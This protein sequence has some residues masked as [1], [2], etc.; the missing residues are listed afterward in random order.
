VTNLPVEEFS[1]ELVEQ[2]YR[3]RWEVETFYRMAKSGFGMNELSTEQPH[4][5]RALVRS[6]L[7]RTTIAMQARI[8]A[9]GFVDTGRW[10]NPTQWIIVWRTVLPDLLREAIQRTGITCHHTWA[11]LARSATDPNRRRPP[12]R[13]TLALG[14][15]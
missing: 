1:P 15:L 4:V 7:V 8:E 13:W 6:A 2:L 9:E 11:T 10:I 12:T 3:L 5:V 14:V